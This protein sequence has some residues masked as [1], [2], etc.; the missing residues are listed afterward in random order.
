VCEPPDRMINAGELEPILMGLLAK[1]PVNR[2]DIARATVELRNMLNVTVDGATGTE[3]S[4][5]YLDRDETAESE[6]VHK[7]G[8]AP[9]PRPSRKRRATTGVSD[10]GGRRSAPVRRGS[11][12]AVTRHTAPPDPV[13]TPSEQTSSGS[14]TSGRHRRVMTTSK[15]RRSAKRARKAEERGSSWR[16]RGHKSP[17]RVWVALFALLAVLIGGGVAAYY[18]TTASDSS[19]SANTQ[20]P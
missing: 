3:T 5:T 13:E 7:V 17:I 19:A 20:S 14:T 10:A 18:F 6:I 15:D 1:D 4:G 16:H 2:W 8:R 11:R 12:R 9:R